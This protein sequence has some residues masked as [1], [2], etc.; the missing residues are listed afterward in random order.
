VVGRS[1]RDVLAWLMKGRIAPYV[2]WI[3]F[4]LG[5]RALESASFR[6]SE[7]FIFHISTSGY[8]VR[9]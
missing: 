1:A 3:F 2:Y 7:D 8:K 4:F 9:L 6:E 5:F